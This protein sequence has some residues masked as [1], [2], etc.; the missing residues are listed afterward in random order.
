MLD[1]LDKGSQKLAIAKS[2]QRE[3]FFL[4]DR[5]DD[6]ATRFTKGVSQGEKLCFLYPCSKELI[7]LLQLILRFNPVQIYKK[8]REKAGIIC[9]CCGGARMEIVQTMISTKKETIRLALLDIMT[10]SH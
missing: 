3:I 9:K 6:Y 8:I 2:K 5:G 10:R 4:G 1:A 7:Q